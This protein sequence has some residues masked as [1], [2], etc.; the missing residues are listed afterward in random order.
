MLTRPRQEIRLRRIG[1]QAAGHSRRHGKPL[2]PVAAA[3]GLGSAFR[4]VQGAGGGNS[5]RRFVEKQDIG[6]RFVP[7]TCQFDIWARRMAP[8]PSSATSWAFLLFPSCH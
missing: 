1:R 3:A 6:Y 4:Y 5:R 8:M 7:K 2:H